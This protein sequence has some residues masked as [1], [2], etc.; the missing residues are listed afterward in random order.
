VTDRQTDGRN[1][2]STYNARDYVLSR[3]KTVALPGFDTTG[4]SVVARVKNGGYRESD[5]G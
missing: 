1:C 4:S 3:V 2:H 5:L